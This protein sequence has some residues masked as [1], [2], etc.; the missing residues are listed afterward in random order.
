MKINNVPEYAWK[1]K[2]I[3]YQ[4]VNGEHWFFGAYD[5]IS[6]SL[7]AMNE[8]GGSIIETSEVEHDTV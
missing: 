2:F 6:K 1:H 3:V 4:T 5:E 7:C 8:C